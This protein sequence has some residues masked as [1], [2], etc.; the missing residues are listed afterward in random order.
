MKTLLQQYEFEFVQRLLP[1]LDSEGR[2]QEFFPQESYSGKSKHSLHRYGEGAFCRFSIHP[3]WSKVS[4]VYA[5]F[6]DDDLAYIGQCIDFAGRINL[7][8]GHISP[9]NCYM[10]GQSTNCKMNKAVLHVVKEG[11]VVDLYFHPTSHYD[12]VELKLIEH[13]KP[14]LNTMMRTSQRLAA[15]DKV[16]IPSKE[17]SVRRNVNPAASNPTTDDIRLYI[18]NLLVAA[19]Q[20]GKHHLIL[21][22]GDVHKDLN[23]KN[24][25]PTV[26]SAMRSLGKTQKYDV[27]EQPPKENGSRLILKYLL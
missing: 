4:G 15:R 1:V 19:Q 8:Y 14:P 9:R 2:I 11:S 13:L 3:K 16:H 18:R 27:I 12:E 5:F 10:G 24:G 20:H 26:C 21:K 25:M 6:I 7:G 22:S 23:M 17:Q